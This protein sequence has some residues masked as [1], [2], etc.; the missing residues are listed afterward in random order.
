[1]EQDI[2]ELFI[3]EEN[4]FSGIEAISIV[5]YP[6]IEE[7]FIALK[8]QTI[9]LAEVDAEKRILMGAALVPDKKIF[10]K[11]GDKEY[12]IYFSKDTVR[13]ASELFLSKGKQNN[14]T[15]EHDVELEGLSVVE[16]WIIEDEKKDKSAKYNLNL[17]VGTWMV[18]VKVNN[19]QIW[20]EFVKEGKVRGFSIEGFFTDKLDE[21]PRESVK[22]EIDSEE[23]EA[24]AKI[25]ELEDII[26]SQYDIELETY[27]D[28][29]KAARNNARRA[30]DYKKKN[31]S[32]CGTPVGW[33][34]ASQLASGANLSRSTIARMASFKR[35]QQNKDVP[36]SEGCGGIMWDAWGGSAGINWAISKLKQIDKK[37]LSKEFVPVNDDYI[38]INDRLAYST[39]EQA[40]KMAK[41]LKCEGFHVHEIDDKEWFM[42][43]KE[44][45][46]A[47]VGPKGGIRKSPKA[48]KSDTPN[49]NPK[50]KGS[51]G[52]S[53]K[54][55][56]G[57][58]VSAKDRATL[59]KKAD[60]FNKR[61]K[62]KL[63]YGVTVGMLASVF[64]RGL[65]AFNTS[66]SPN[67][68][69]AS[70]W[71]F[72]R[73]NAFLYLVKN[74]RP[75]NPKYTTDYDLLPKKHPKSPK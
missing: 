41:D 72:A 25:F 49:K 45:F 34:R 27:S 58:K 18:S 26:L 42:P 10:R 9:Q 31:G 38:I 8:E 70:Q 73:T 68:K 47:E 57:A 65:G 60:D 55:K 71:A 52:G 15:L 74:G 37:K 29:P 39:K 17:P 51:A 67:V 2:I 32:S 16:S 35:H 46:L 64:Q 6:A 63:G 66:H 4:D 50:G 30:L 28:Y 24:L 7:D 75:Q 59:Q 19:D 22:E 40:E 56:T 14:S 21:R 13:K 54:G 33:R 43:C 12:F 53:A 3:D 11:S 61:Y 23:L 5:E 69:S 36:Y 48:P 44:H 20:E 62:E 1:M